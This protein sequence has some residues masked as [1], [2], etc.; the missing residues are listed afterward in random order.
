MKLAFGHYNIVEHLEENCIAFRA[1]AGKKGV[2]V[3]FSASEE[4]K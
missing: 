4:K 3:T 1:L 2:N